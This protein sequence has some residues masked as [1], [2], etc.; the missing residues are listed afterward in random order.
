MLST[1][2]FTITDVKVPAANNTGLVKRVTRDWRDD[3]KC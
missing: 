2:A 3:W 1:A